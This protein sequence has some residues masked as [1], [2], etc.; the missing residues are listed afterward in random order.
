MTV[1]DKRHRGIVNGI[2]QNESMIYKIS[3]HQTST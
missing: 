3:H 1:T 2:A